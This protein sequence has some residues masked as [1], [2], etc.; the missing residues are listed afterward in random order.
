M[1]LLLLILLAVLPSVL[2]AVFLYYQDKHEKEEHRHLWAAFGW[3][4]LTIV[5]SFFFA[6]L[7]IEGGESPLYHAFVVAALP[8]EFFKFAF[9]Y[10]F[11][12]HKAYFNEPYDG[13]IYAA[14]V[15]LGFA[16]LE[17]LMYILDI[18][19]QKGWQEGLQV[20]WLRM[21]MAIPGH[22]TW[23]IFMGFYLGVAKFH[24]RSPWPYLLWGLL[25][26]VLAHGSYDYFLF[27]KKFQYLASLAVV[28]I[29]LGVAVAY[30]AMRIHQARSPFK[31]VRSGA[32]E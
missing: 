16:T 2:I 4:C 8:E 9:L 24:P 32:A 29:V 12:F 27:E 7:L 10:F 6:S 15:S 20:A 21:L 30:R 25:V 18:Y 26:A 22:A 14:F 1:A 13:I 23:G 28:M 3:G 17:N 31:P 19:A 11:I 5:P